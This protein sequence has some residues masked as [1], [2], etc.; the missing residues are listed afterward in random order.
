[1]TGSLWSMI[2]KEFDNEMGKQKRKVLL[3]VD[4]AACHKVNGL[5]VENVKITFLPPNTTSLL[6]PLDQ[7]II[8]CFKVYFRQIMVRKQI[9]AIE[10]GLS[11]KQ[12][13]TSISILDAL[14]FIK[15][16]W[17]LVK[18]DTIRN[19]FQKAGFQVEDISFDHIE[20]I[21]DVPIEIHNFD[22]YVAC[23][24]ALIALV[25]LLMRK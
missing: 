13:I 23:D 22:E 8:H 24:S 15:R 19:C 10:N 4:N 2:M 11:I 5:N 16:A 18:S 9:L 20:E 1:M 17:W 25:F 12:F 21:V 6:Q 7:G 14:N 3:I